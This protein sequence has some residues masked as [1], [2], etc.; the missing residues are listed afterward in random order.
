[1]NMSSPSTQFAPTTRM[2]IFE[3]FH[4]MSI[5]EDTFRGDIMPGTGACM[6]AQP[7]DRVDDKVKQ[8]ICI[9]WLIKSKFLQLSD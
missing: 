9:F 1:M 8:H 6:V 5:W 3:P 7:N 4:H 2:G